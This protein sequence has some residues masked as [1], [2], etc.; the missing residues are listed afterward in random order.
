M[1]IRPLCHPLCWL[2]IAPAAAF[3]SGTPG[4]AGQAGAFLRLGVGARAGS[5]G[6]AFVAAASGPM[7]LYW[8]PAGLEQ[9]RG[10]KFEASQRR[11]SLQR[12]F[13]FAGLT[14]PISQRS[15]VGLG[16][17]GFSTEGIA[18]RSGNTAEPDGYFSDRENALLLSASHRLT[19]W[20]AIGAT[21]KTIW[22]S[23][24]NE[25][26]SG[27]SA[28]AGAQLFLHERLTLGATYQDFYSTYKWKDGRWENFPRTSMAGAAWRLGAHSLITL[29][30][31]ETENEIGRVR[32]GLEFT[33]ISS[34]PVRVGYSRNA[35]AAGA[36]L[37]TALGAHALRIDYH[38]S[39]QEGINDHA[40][41]FSLAIDFNGAHRINSWDGS[42]AAIARPRAPSS[43]ATPAWKAS[44]QPIKKLIK[45]NTLQLNVRSGPGTQYKVIGKL[46]RG[47]KRE[48]IRRWNDWYELKLDKKKR[49]WVNKEFVEEM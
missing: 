37:E 30:Y 49:G 35:F 34:L 48:A 10:W 32:A 4:V 1:N 38:F 36:G 25:S 24:F 18:A 14:F 11:F 27:Y 17:I 3:S 15:S 19:D 7:A 42:F 22:Q 9:N 33:S 31:H 6:D 20:L 23:L 45:I 8:N 5:L 43:R 16:W 47:A 41:A 2:L 21:T 46:D 28:S 29:D 39:S 12:N 26:A 13:S 44:A 40:H